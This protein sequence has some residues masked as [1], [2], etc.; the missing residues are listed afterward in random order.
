LG[1]ALAGF[2]SA[3]GVSRLGHPE[4]RAGFLFWSAVAV[5]VLSLPLAL[6]RSLNLIMLY[7][8]G[9]AISMSIFNVPLFAAHMR[10]IESKRRFSHRRADAMALREVV[11]NLGRAVAC[12][13]VLW[14]VHDIGSVGLTWLIVGV[15]FTPLL[16]Y[17]VMRSHLNDR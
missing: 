10:V 17:R 5:A 3:W 16:N 14:G 7:G 13:V 1:T 15:A 9:M 11:L 12:A 6:H 8:L 2:A 4:R